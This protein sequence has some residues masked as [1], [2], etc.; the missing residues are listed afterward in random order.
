MRLS[1]IPINPRNHPL[2]YAIASGLLCTHVALAAFAGALP[3]KIAA[4]VAGTIYVPLWLF[5]AIGLPVFQ[6][7]PFGGGRHPRCSV[8]SCSPPSGPWSGGN[9]SPP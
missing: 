2:R 7:N 9:W 1:P 4:A 3:D 6:A 5:N 8:G